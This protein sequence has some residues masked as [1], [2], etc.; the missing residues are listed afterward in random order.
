M[1]PI[2]NAERHA[3]ARPEPRRTLRSR[4]ADAFEAL[5]AA[6]EAED[7]CTVWIADRL[8]E[9]EQGRS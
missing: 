3:N 2:Q 6:S 9:R 4:Q 8:L 1:L 7:I 5:A